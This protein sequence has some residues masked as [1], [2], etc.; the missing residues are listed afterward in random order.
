MNVYFASMPVVAVV[1]M[2]LLP[3]VAVALPLPS[4]IHVAQ[5]AGDPVALVD[6]NQPIQIQVVNAGG[7][8]ITCRLTQPPTDDR[9][10]VPGSNVTFGSTRTSYLPVP[11]NLLV[12]PE[13]Q[14]IGLSLYVTVEKNAVKVVVAEARSD[15]PGSTSMRISLDGGIYVY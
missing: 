6:P 9:R 4:T 12:S 3:I 1:A 8:P 5:N 11:I 15:I 7:A 13:Q 2:S 14:N 10:V